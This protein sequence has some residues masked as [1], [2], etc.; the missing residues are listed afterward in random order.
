MQLAVGL[1][2]CESQLGQ[3]YGNSGL[4]DV[5]GEQEVGLATERHKSDTELKGLQ[6]LYDMGL[7]P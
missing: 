3:L 1:A 2:G 6:W 4:K 7:R 5:P